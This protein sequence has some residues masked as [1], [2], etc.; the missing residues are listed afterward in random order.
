LDGGENLRLPFDDATR[1]AY[2]KLLDEMFDSNFLSDGPLTVRFEEAFAEFN[3]IPYAVAL[4][5]GGTGLLGILEFLDVRGKEVIVPT[6]TFMATPLAVRRAGGKIVFADCSRKDLCV[7][8][9]EIMRLA[10]QDTKAAIVVHI[11]GHITFQIEEIA[12]FCTAKGI[13]LVEDCAHAHGASY[14]GKA[15]G[16]WG[17]AGAYSFYATKTMP[18]G[19]GGMVITHQQELADWLKVWRN[20][21]KKVEQVRGKSLISYPLLNGFHARMPEAVAALG[22]VQ[23]HR[24]PE[25]LEWKRVLAAKY[26]HIFENR[27]RLPDGMESGLYKYIVF[28][29]PLKERTGS[30]FGELCHW[31]LHDGRSYQESEWVAAHHCCPPIYYGWDGA[32][33]SVE[34]LRARL[35]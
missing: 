15:A 9:D 34:E 21:G 20:Y 29:Y 14:H 7:T 12:A 32:E 2:Y 35:L 11:G 17:V 10:G 6:N 19:E 22:I 28:D 3:K 25:I 4:S 18:T 33:L 23:L 5:S 31:F 27:I 13:A 30:V 16:S 26:D 24:L 8:A 1:R